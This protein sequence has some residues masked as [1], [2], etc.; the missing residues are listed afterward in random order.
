[1]A[2]SNGHYSDRLIQVFAT[3]TQHLEQF[4]KASSSDADAFILIENV[5]EE[6]QAA[7]QKCLS[8]IL[9]AADLAS[10]SATLGQ[11]HMS[12][13]KTTLPRE[14][15][16]PPEHITGACG[17]AETNEKRVNQNAECDTF[18]AN[19]ALLQPAETLSS[20]WE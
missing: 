16:N 11:V 19:L 10:F 6:D 18:S 3:L 7:A 13:L 9:G 2:F 20:Y 5:A 14:A 8:K 12:N 1:V 4:P 17:S 15:V